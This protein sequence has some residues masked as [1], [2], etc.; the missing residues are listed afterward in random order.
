MGGNLRELAKKDDYTGHITAR[1]LQEGGLIPY[2]VSASLFGTYLMGHLTTNEE[3]LIIEGF[4]R[5]KE[6]VTALDSAM[7]FYKREHPTI[8]WIELSDDTA[9]KRLL[10]RG[11]PDDREESIRTRL[12]W[13]RKETAPNIEWFRKNP[14]Y[15]VI[16]VDGEG[17]IE[18]THKEILRKL[19]L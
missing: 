10:A 4:P 5:Q 16:D 3:H 19:A 11:R 2:A 7:Q 12:T 17:T 1:I 14:A 8:V 6:Q 9:V 15:R 13:S 18:D